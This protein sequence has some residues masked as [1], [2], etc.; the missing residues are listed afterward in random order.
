MFLF[1]PRYCYP[2]TLLFLFLYT[3]L[4]VFLVCY[5]SSFHLHCFHVC[6]V[7]R[8]TLICILL[9]ASDIQTNSYIFKYSTYICT[10]ILYL[11]YLSTTMLAYTYQ[12]AKKK[13]TILFHALFRLFSLLFCSVDV[14]GLVT[15]FECT[16]VC[17]YIWIC[18]IFPQI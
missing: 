7:I 18:K 3:F 4:V 11:F 1:I 6:I 10:Y 8:N 9:I 5:P 2:Y 16:W 14:C 12:N 17:L 13:I 15:I